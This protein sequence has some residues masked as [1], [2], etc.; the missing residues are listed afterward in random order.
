MSMGRDYVPELLP[1][2]DLLF[3]T[4]MIYECGLWWYDIDRGK[5]KHSEKNH[6]QCHFVYHKPY[7]D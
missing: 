6:S 2:T 7:M 3:I 4:R 1:S 5:P